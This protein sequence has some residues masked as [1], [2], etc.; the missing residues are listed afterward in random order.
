MTK[1]DV[2]EIF[3]LR[4]DEKVMQYIDRKRAESLEDAEQWL[5]IVD[6]ALDK[7]TGITWGISMR[8]SPAVLIG[9]IGYWR[10][11]KE[12]YRAEVGYMLNALLWR[13][14]IMKE[15]LNKIITFGFD[16]LKLHSIEAHINTANTASAGILTSSGFIQEAYFKENYFFEGTFR[17][18]KV[19]SLL[20]PHS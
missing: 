17:D 14:G 12:H 10:L 13:K 2:P 8:E 19:Y 20:V 1:A 9:S 6:E 5:Q 18:T 3:K 4:S 11:I 16:E 15:A 7:K